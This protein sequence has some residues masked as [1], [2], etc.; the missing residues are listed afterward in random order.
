MC[1]WCVVS[2]RLLICC[3]RFWC[4]WCLPFAIVGGVGVVV[5]VV[6]VEWL[7]IAKIYIVRGTDLSKF[8]F[9]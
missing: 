2:F 5:G 4:W 3:W 9:R 7:I 1:C 6:L 8:V